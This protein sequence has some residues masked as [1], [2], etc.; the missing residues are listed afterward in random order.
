MQSVHTCSMLYIHT[1]YAIQRNRDAEFRSILSH[2]KYLCENIKT[3]QH[4][5]RERSDEYLILTQDPDKC[6]SCRY[7]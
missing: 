1:M 2:K 4:C 5:I 3:M 6:C 7:L